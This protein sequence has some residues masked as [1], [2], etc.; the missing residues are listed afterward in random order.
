M[1][2]VPFVYKSRLINTLLDR[3]YKINSSWSG[4]DIDVK[5]LCKY[6]LWNLYSKRLI[7]KR[8]NRFLDKQ[9]GVDKQNENSNNENGKKMRYIT[10]SLVGDCLKTAKIKIKKWITKFCK[11]N[12]HGGSFDLVVR[13]E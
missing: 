9:N 12:I 1:S 4:F 11:P 10:L 13:P 6:L 2:F 7:D 5:I 3:T 8:I